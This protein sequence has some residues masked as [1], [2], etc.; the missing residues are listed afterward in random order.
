MLSCERRVYYAKI[1]FEI[2]NFKKKIQ[3]QNTF[4]KVQLKILYGKLHYEENTARKNTVRR[5][6]FMPAY[7]PRY[8]FAL[9]L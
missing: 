3:L 5:M 9:Q 7:T 8:L 4:W 2:I 1:Q 6:H